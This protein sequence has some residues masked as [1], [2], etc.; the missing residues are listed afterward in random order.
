MTIE[1]K[2]PEGSTPLK[3]EE[4]ERLIPTHITTME[5]LNEAEQLNIAAASLW[6]LGGR[7][8]D[9]LS[10]KFAKSLH[11]R[12]FED[13]WRWAGKYRTRAVN[14]GNIEA[15][16]IGIRLHQLFDD[17]R[18]WIEND[19]YEPDETAARLH[20]GLTLI[21]PFP[22]GNG[23]HARLMADILLRNMDQSPFTWG[24]DDLARQGGVRDRYLAALRAADGHDIGP[25]IEFARY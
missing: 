11:K 3:A 12:M 19:V 10:E 22:N 23:R 15:Y 2:T 1:F 5:Q 20:H 6:A 24:S 18:H 9:V 7:R 17:V 14:I 8:S 16:D 4:L 25:L 13:V 21:H